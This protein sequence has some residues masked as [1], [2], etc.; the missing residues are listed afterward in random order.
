VL[1]FLFVFPHFSDLATMHVRMEEARQKLAKYESEIVQTN[2]YMRSIREMEKEGSDV[3]PEEQSLQFAN[4]VQAQAVQSGVRLS[5]VSPIKTQTNQFF[6]EK[7]LSINAQGAE[8]QLVD[9]LYNLGSGNSQI[10][11]RGLTLRP[12]PPRHELVAS[13]T[14]VASYQK[15]ATARPATPAAPATGLRTP[16]PSAK[17]AAPT[18]K[19]EPPSGKTA[20]PPLTR[21]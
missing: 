17:P 14:L 13:V 19:S 1:N 8:Q 20:N 3:A 11:V 21:P 15:K 16:A 12:D 6:L 10:R 4:T 18:P 9:F 2:A 5:S 7:S